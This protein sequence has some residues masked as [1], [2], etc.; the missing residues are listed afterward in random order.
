ML[1]PQCYCSEIVEIGFRE[2]LLRTTKGSFGKVKE[3]EDCCLHKRPFLA[4]G[5]KVER[6]DEGHICLL[7]LNNAG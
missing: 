4:S 5:H 1:S 6:M 2:Q 3:R 7:K